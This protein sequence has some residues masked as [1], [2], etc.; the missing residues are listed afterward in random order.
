MNRQHP[1]DQHVSVWLQHVQPERG[2][3][4]RKT[5]W[6]LHICRTPA[7]RLTSARA[8]PPRAGHE[9]IQFHRAARANMPP[10]SWSVTGTLAWASA[11]AISSSARPYLP[12]SM[13]W[14]S[15]GI[16]RMD[17]VRALGRIRSPSQAVALCGAW[18]RPSRNNGN[19][20]WRYLEFL[21]VTCLIAADIFVREYQ[22]GREP[23]IG[24]AQL[25]CPNTDTD[26]SDQSVP[27]LFAPLFLEGRDCT[28]VRLPTAPRRTPGRRGR[29]GRAGR[30]PA[31]VRRDLV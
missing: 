16:Q 11:P 17:L 4:Q 2:R 14:C 26:H 28:R 15:Y 29:A 23:G 27:V 5:R 1:A 9:I 13:T 3:Y 8:E 20:E 6:P 24:P 22:V 19:G 18:D 25:T 21:Q 10:R 12:T 7:R 30:G 31:P